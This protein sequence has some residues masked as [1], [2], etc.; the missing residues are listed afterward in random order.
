M[1]ESSEAV[2]PGGL[3]FLK[4]VSDIERDVATNSLAQLAHVD[5]TAS[6]AFEAIGDL[7]GLLDCGAS[8]FWGCKGGDHRR[9]MLVGR[10]VSTSYA[11]IRLMVGGYYDESLSLIR[12][13]G[14]VA[15]LVALFR[16]DDKALMTWK[17]IDERERRRLFSALKVR[18]ALERIVG[19]IPITE[20]RYSALSSFAIHVDPAT[21]PQAHNRHRLSRMVPVLQEAGV[22]MCINE[23]TIALAFIGLLGPGLLDLA[24]ERRAAII[25]A[26]K[27]LTK[28]LGD[29][30]ATELNRPWFQKFTQSETAGPTE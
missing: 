10:A 12:T 3:L 28:H 29:I 6:R 27:A 8:C 1:D 24:K 30:Q 19:V 14:E 26:A 16:V 20:E 5:N 11:A 2:L 18:L 4:S 17:T 22:L 15:N 13:V 9:E 23:L 21:M 25:D 7:L